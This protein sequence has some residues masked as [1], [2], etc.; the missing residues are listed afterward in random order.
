MKDEMEL[1]PSCRLL[2][3]HLCFVFAIVC[4]CMP[5]DHD[6]LINFHNAVLVLQNMMIKAILISAHF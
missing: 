3:L 4:I 6:F 5:D 2:C 1:C